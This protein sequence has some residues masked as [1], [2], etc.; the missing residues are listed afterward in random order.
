MARKKKWLY[1]ASIGR[2]KGLAEGMVYEF[3]PKFQRDGSVKCKILGDA[4][5]QKLTFGYNSAADF[6]EDWEEV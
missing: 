5:T 4:F 1:K 3:N 6:E 2:V